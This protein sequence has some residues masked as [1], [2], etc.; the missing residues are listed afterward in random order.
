[1]RIEHPEGI[2]HRGRGHP[3]SADSVALEIADRRIS[4]V[5]IEVAGDNEGVLII[6]GL[7][8]TGEK[9]H[10]LFAGRLGE[11]VQMEIIMDTGRRTAN[12]ELQTLYACD[13]EV[14]CRRRFVESAYR[15]CLGG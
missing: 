6:A 3:K 13:V 8:T 9:L 15:R 7:D 2:D 4:F 10:T 5:G 11:V 14:S 12:Y 1:M